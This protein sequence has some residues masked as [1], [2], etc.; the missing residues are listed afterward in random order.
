HY[1]LLN[2]EPIGD[3]LTTLPELGAIVKLAYT[4]E[5]RENYKDA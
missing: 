3:L 2:W 5:L 4:H 1:N